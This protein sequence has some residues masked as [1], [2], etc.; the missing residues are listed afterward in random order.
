[1]NAPQ[2]LVYCAR[3]S[4]THIRPDGTQLVPVAAR[5]REIR[6]A[7][8]TQTSSG[9]TKEVGLIRTGFT[10]CAG[11]PEPS[12]LTWHIVSRR[13]AGTLPYRTSPLVPHNVTRT[14]VGRIYDRPVLASRASR[15]L[16]G[17][18]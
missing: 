3:H 16:K 18:S 9:G 13:V 6:R 7:A 10:D 8:A 12:P 14:P 15:R 17:E 2:R 1:M 11:L 4:V 5:C